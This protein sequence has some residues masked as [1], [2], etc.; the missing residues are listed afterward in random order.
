MIQW[1]NQHLI[2]SVIVM[3]TTIMIMILMLMMMMM[4]MKM[5]MTMIMKMMMMIKITYE[6]CIQLG[7]LIISLYSPAGRYSCYFKSALSS[8][9]TIYLSLY[10]CLYEECLSGISWGARKITK[11]ECL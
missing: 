9:L 10:R 5:M 1:N 11:I 2:A 6:Y 7:V 3:M 4:V 8:T